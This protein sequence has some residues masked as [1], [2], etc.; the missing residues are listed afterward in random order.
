MVLATCGGAEF[1]MKLTAEEYRRRVEGCWI[2]KNIGGTLGMPMEWNRSIN[3][4]SYYTHDISGEP[5]PNDDLDIQVLWLMAL[6]DHGLKVDA[7]ILGQYFNELMIFTHAEY[8]TA[9]ANM[10][11]GLEPPYSGIYK[12]DFKHSCGSFIRSE[13]WACLFP[14]YPQLAAKYAFEDAIVDHGDGEGVYAEVFTAALESAAFFEQDLEK[15]IEIGLSYIPADCVVA[16]AIR[17]GADLARRGV[18]KEEARDHMMQSYIGHIEWHY[19]S[20][21]DEAKGYGEG[22][23]GFD[24]PSNMFIIAYN[25]VAGKGDLEKS[26]CDAVWFGEDTDCTAGTIAALHGIRFGIDSIEK[27]WIEPIGTKIKTISI[28]PFRM[29]ARIPKDI[30]EFSARVEKIHEQAV[31]EY[32]LSDEPT[33]DLMAPA[34]FTN[35]YDDMHVV[36]YRFD[37]IN[38]RLDYMGDPVIHAGEPKRIRFLISNTAKSVSTERINLH[39]YTAD[40]MQVAPAKEL[41]TLVTMGHMGSGISAVEF[42]LFLEQTTRPLYRGVLELTL[43]DSKKGRLFHVPFVLL[44]EGGVHVDSKFEKN[45][46]PMCPNQPRV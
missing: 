34:W 7:K 30:Y 20:P 41:S 3:D 22:P 24:V 15:L 8:G 39:L 28:D 12:N 9:K 2:G 10:R 26:M 43:E 27:K 46:P 25:L 36:T 6:E 23:F 13:I 45:G 11:V 31:Q 42:E 1:E 14:G 29:E 4:I 18:S 19:M 40:E 5:L 16:R 33:H 35:I 21:E 44:N 32:A 37:Y 38:V 17:E